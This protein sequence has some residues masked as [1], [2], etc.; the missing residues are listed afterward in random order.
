MEKNMEVA[1]QGLGFRVQGGNEGIEKKM[2]ATVMALQRDY[3][4]DPFLPS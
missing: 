3:Y 4:K 1:I 2:K